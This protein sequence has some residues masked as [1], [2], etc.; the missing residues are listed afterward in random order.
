MTF[1]EQSQNYKRGNVRYLEYQADIDFS[2]P[3]AI[4]INR[5]TLSDKHYQI[6]SRTTNLER[7]TS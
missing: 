5:D 2:T 6:V 1:D 3:P 7:N 4:Y